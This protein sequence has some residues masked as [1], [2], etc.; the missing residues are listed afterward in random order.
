MIR[1]ILITTFSVLALPAASQVFDMTK[2][3]P[4]GFCPKVSKTTGAIQYWTRPGGSEMPEYESEGSDSISQLLPDDGDEDGDGHGAVTDAE[5]VA[6]V[7]VATKEVVV[8]TNNLAAVTL[9]KSAA[10]NPCS[11]PVNRTV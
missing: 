8:A 5:G 7:A 2:C 11:D 6:D 10:V 4:D 1:I 3:R 9:P